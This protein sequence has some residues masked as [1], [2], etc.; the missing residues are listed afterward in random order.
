M[1][2]SQESKGGTI[3][4]MTYIGEKELLK[5]TSYRKTGH[6]VKDGVAIPK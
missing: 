5:P 3:D 6:Q 1:E 2:D 4:E